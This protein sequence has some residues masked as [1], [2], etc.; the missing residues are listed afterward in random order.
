VLSEAV[1]IYFADVTFASAFV[2]RW[3]VGSRVEPPGGVLQVRDDEPALRV[4]PGLH[5]I[6]RGQGSKTSAYRN[7]VNPKS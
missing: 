1:S 4:G 5:R 7:C 3:C 6:P 2:G